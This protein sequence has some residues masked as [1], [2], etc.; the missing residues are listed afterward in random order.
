M[1]SM[2]LLIFVHSF[3]YSTAWVLRLWVFLCGKANK[4]IMTMVTLF[5]KPAKSTS[6][7]PPMTPPTLCWMLNEPTALNLPLQPNEL[8]IFSSTVGLWDIPMPVPMTTAA[9]PNANDNDDDNWYWCLLLLIAGDSSAIT[10]AF[11]L[12][13]D[14]FYNDFCNFV[15]LTRALL[16]HHKNKPASLTA[17]FDAATSKL[18]ATADPEPTHDASSDLDNL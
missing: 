11:L 4:V 14:E 10:P 2:C 7:S 13:W 9:A 17:V 5:G 3:G 6:H 1:N 18:P 12:Q 15:H 8:H 16:S